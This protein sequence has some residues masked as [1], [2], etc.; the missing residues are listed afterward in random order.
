MYADLITHYETNGHSRISSAT[1]PQ[2]ASW[3]A[4]QEHK[5]M[6]NSLTPGQVQQLA[7]MKVTFIHSN[8]SK[9]GIKC[10]EKKCTKFGAFEGKCHEHYYAMYRRDHPAPEPTVVH[11]PKEKKKKKAAKGKKTKAKVKKSPVKK[12]AKKATKKSAVKDTKVDESE[13]MVPL[14]PPMDCPV[15]D[16]EMA[17]AEKSDEA[18]KTD[19]ENAAS[20][21]DSVAAAKSDGD[22]VD[23]A[24][25]D[26]KKK[27]DE[28]IKTAA[29][30][31]KPSKENEAVGAAAKSIG[32]SKEAA[33]S[34][35]ANDD[36]EVTSPSKKAETTPAADKNDDASLGSIHSPDISVAGNGDGAEKS[37]FKTDSAGRPIVDKE[38]EASVKKDQDPPVPANQKK[39]KANASSPKKKPSKKAAAAKGKDKTAKQILIPANFKGSKPVNPVIA[40]A[41]NTML[42]SYPPAKSR[43]PIAE[44]MM[45]PQPV[46]QYPY[47][48]SWPAAAPAQ[49]PQPKAPTLQDQH[50]R[51]IW[52]KHYGSLILFYERFGH[53]DV[54]VQQSK[55]LAPPSLVTW[56]SQQRDRMNKGLLTEDE[57]KRL[58]LLSFRQASTGTEVMEKQRCIKEDCNKF[59]VFN[60]KCHAHYT[61]TGKLRKRQAAPDA[62]AYNYFNEPTSKK[63][64]TMKL[65]QAQ[66]RSIDSKIAFPPG[67]SGAAMV[68]IPGVYAG[69][70]QT[71]QEKK[72]AVVKKKLVKAIKPKF[73]LVNSSRQK[74]GLWTLTISDDKAKDEPEKSKE[75]E[76]E[77][78]EEPAEEP[79]EEKEK[80]QEGET[81]ALKKARGRPKGSR[82]KVM[83]L[84]DQT[85]DQVIEKIGHYV[86]LLANAHYC[87]NERHYYTECTCMHYLRNNSF[88]VKAVSTAIFD[89]YGKSHTDKRH[90]TLERMRMGE[91]PKSNGQ[92]DQKGN[93]RFFTLPLVYEYI[94][95][96]E[97]TVNGG[98]SREDQIG[99][100]FKHKI[101]SSS[102]HNLHDNGRKVQ[103]TM[104][105]YLD[106]DT[107]VARHRVSC[108]IIHASLHDVTLL[109]LCVVVYRALESNASAIAVQERVCLKCCKP[110]M[111]N[112]RL[113]TAPMK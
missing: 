99:T 53:S 77:K 50:S 109:N 92:T 70:L 93:Q 51:N 59:A 48:Y 89:Y 40:A 23:A 31:D 6:H 7:L 38:V 42:A 73:P 1:N 102:W 81:T 108:S 43:P 84:K 62:A 85:T 46:Y 44:G 78:P 57:V 5:H 34:K 8:E 66:A 41:V 55:E 80:E 63:S 4:D 45:P 96:I 47:P 100:L 33:S 37:E 39:P 56:V 49:A 61:Q 94:D 82:L 29:A 101:C 12:V 71:F 26:E 107:S 98:K 110:Y 64:K 95:N 25:D 105:K 72:A 54:T 113:P 87:I 111:M 79:V 10:G 83:K 11:D 35:S 103:E 19:D 76:T 3:L 106:G 88:A 97:L 74:N 13:I 22:K 28:A 14:L 68:R 9:L 104:Q 16:G 112:T 24:D 67:R 36:E 15:K 21:K 17:D 69:V 32:E 18:R 91:Q 30:E 65:T 52:L 20:L 2:L 90:Y 60:G 58:D 27:S 86:T 75:P